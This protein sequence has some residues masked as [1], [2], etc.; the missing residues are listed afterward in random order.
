M[1]SIDTERL[2]LRDVQ[3]SDERAMAALRMDPVV[4]QYNEYILSRTP[5]EVHAW[6]VDTMDHNSRVP[7]YAWNLTIVR[8]ADG[9]M[10]GWIGLGQGSDPE[11][12]DLDFAY[13]SSPRTGARV[14]PR[15]RSMPCWTGV[16]RTWTSSASMASAMSA[17]RARR[18]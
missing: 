11:R 13:A 12:G 5:E 10:L 14:T 6:I 7:R 15:R 4:T 17:T 3:L 2:L 8:R 18:G 1:F 16:S 9:A